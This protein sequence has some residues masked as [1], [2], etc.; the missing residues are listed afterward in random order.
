MEEVKRSLVACMKAGY[1]LLHVD[2]TVDRTLPSG[3]AIAIETVVARTV[4]LIEHAERE[5]ERLGLPPVSYEVGTEEVHG[6]LVDHSN[7]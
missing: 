4:E 7:F 3:E 2:P 6:G 5:R 1:H